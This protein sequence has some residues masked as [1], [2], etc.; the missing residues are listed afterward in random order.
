MKRITLTV[1]ILALAG[2]LQCGAAAAQPKSLIDFYELALESDPEFQAAA[3]TNAAAQELTPQARSFLLPNVS[4]GGFARHNWL[5]VDKSAGI[6]NLGSRDFNT[7][8]ADISLTQ[9]IYRH[10]LWVALGQADIRTKQANADYAFARQELMIRAATR[11]FDV[12]R[13]QDQLT[14]AKA[15]LEAFGQQLKQAQQRFEVGLIAITD[16]EEAQSGFDLATADVIAAENDLD[17]A[18]EAQREVAGTYIEELKPLEG[19]IPLVTPAPDDIDLWTETALRQN[20]QV[21]AARFAAENAR[22]EISRI[23]AGHLPTLDLVGRSVYFNADGGVSGASRSTDSQIGLELTVP[24]Y[25]GG[26]INSQTRESQHLYQR[27]LDDLE[28][29]R[30]AVQRQTRDAF[31]GIKSNISRVKALVQAVRS[32]ISAKEA[33]EAGFQVGTRTSVDVLDA[34]RR[35]FEARRD[36]SFARYDYIVNTLELKQAAGTLSEADM[37]LVNSWLTR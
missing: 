28:R 25:E 11:Y 12:L 18:R 29:Q 3:A 10:D 19:D 31:L 24:I 8:Q 21:T 36:L 15:A 4:A 32:T 34:E 13:A 2:A 14:F 26:L 23:K 17:N 30:R 27:S 20:L 5:D 6:A 37:E 9:P 33:I 35:V 7:Q 1:S 22:E 16:V